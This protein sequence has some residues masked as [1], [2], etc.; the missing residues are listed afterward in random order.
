MVPPATPTRFILLA[1][2]HIIIAGVV[3]REG[4][5]V[6]VDLLAPAGRQVRIMKDT[7]LT[8][9]AVLGAIVDGALIPLDDASSQAVEELRKA[10]G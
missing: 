4:Q 3:V 1:R 9:G 6:C 7:P 2:T 5:R 8:P 10:A